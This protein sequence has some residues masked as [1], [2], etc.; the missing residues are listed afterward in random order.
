MIKNYRKGKDGKWCFLCGNS[1][2]Y[3][4]KKEILY[5]CFARKHYVDAVNCCNEFKVKRKDDEDN[6]SNNSGE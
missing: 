2:T 6:P 4:N 5:W 3:K 1:E